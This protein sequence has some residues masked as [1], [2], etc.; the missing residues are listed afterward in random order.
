MWIGQAAKGTFGDRPVQVFNQQVG[1]RAR[2][3][4]NL[5]QIQICS[6]D[7]VFV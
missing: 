4:S 5:R 7:L 1:A 6:T 3:P 2:W